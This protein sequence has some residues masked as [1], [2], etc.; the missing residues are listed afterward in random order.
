MSE[1]EWKRD[2]AAIGLT[3]EQ[4]TDLA[5]NRNPCSVVGAWTRALDQDYF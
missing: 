4:A 2:A 3:L 1:A 5:N